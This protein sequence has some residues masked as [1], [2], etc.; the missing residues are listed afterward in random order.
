M[1]VRFPPEVQN[2]MSPNK[3]IP[4]IDIVWFKRDLRT[5]DHKSLEIVAKS[6][7]P[8]LFIYLFE[9]SVMDY[10]DYDTRH[11]RFIHESLIDIERKL[12]S[13]SLKLYLL[14]CE[15]IV[16][17]EE[18]SKKYEINRVLSYQE[19]GNKLT[20]E[21]DK[22]LFK[23]FKKNN[24]IWI[25]HKTNGIIRGLKSR[26]DWK[27]EWVDEMKSKVSLSD[28]NLIDKT[29]IDVPKKIKFFS[30]KK[31]NDKNFQPGGETFAWMYMNSFLKKDTKVTQKTSV[32]QFIVESHAVGFHLI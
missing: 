23:F 5:L 3:K 11:L 15:A 10:P 2:I 27:K 24:I 29:E 8:V 13:Y 7:N 1:W 4:S 9:P 16:F 14:K 30:L 6:S 25:Q 28:L 22:D 32:A 18:I 20:F 26:K 17:F 12:R 21:R 31:N 19:I